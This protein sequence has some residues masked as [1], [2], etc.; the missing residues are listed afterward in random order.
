MELHGKNIIG[1]SESA[2]G[3]P[4]IAAVNPASG[5]TLAPDFYEAAPSEIDRAMTLAADAF[6]QRRKSDWERTSALL[7]RIADEI[8]ALG[9]SLISRA[10]AE[11]GLPE[12]RLSGERL[13]TV[14]QLRMFAGVV[15]E[16][17]WVEAR[18]DPALPD[19][20]PAPRPDLR[21]MLIPIGPVVVFGASNFPLAFSVAGGDAASAFAAGNPVVVKA[22]PAHPGVSEMVARAIRAAVSATG[23]PDG[24]FSMLHGGPDVSLAL[25]RHPLAEAV[26]FTGSLNAG[27][28]L[29]NAAAA[30]DRPIPVF[31]EM[32][33]VNPVFILPGALKARGEAIAK[34]LADSV[35]LG[36][37]QFCTNP[38]VVVGID[39]SVL[40]EVIRMA[41]E[42]LQK[43]PA[44]VM[45]HQRICDA[46]AA[47]VDRLRT[48]EGV[49]IETTEN[50]GPGARAALFST[51]SANFLSDPSLSQELF[52]PSSLVV[53]CDSPA[54]MMAVARGLEG[55]LT[56]TIHA[57]PEDLEQFAP[58]IE[59]LT[60]RV[61][62]LILNGF[63]TGV[64]VSPAMNH[65][66]PY[67]ASTDIRSTSVGTAAISRFARP[68][69][70]QGFPDAMLPPELQDANPR[71]IW[72]L[73]DG[74]WTKASVAEN[75]A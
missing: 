15:R 4:V 65:G 55:Q 32:G 35:T 3:R 68:I 75:R 53:V 7:D 44:G 41:A 18:I 1:G 73:V 42:Q 67:P 14:G 70:Y 52:G 19:R 57:T 20:K 23:L 51:P 25:V 31:A 27:R 33:S 43:V 50:A 64:E 11:T 48:I 56:A 8:M 72:R 5:E 69:C 21:R 24:T 37:G 61:G 60:A 45:L 59:I 63:P 36:V 9:D 22:H 38:G 54:A 34:G 6:S 47:G 71:G 17:S 40:Q 26:G 66:G 30:R 13:R 46:F 49:T 29:F 2:E 12:G 10:A 58:L 28:A 39:N 16:G 62:R 74:E